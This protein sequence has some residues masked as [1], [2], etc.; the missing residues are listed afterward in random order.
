V[1]PSLTSLLLGVEI[2]LA[3]FFFSVLGLKRHPGLDPGLR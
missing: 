3:S 2:V 1:I